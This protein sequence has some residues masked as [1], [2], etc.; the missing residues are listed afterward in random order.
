MEFVVTELKTKLSEDFKNLVAKKL[1]RFDRFFGEGTVANVKVT[2]EKNLECMEIT[3]HHEGRVYR[4]ES[5]SDS[6]YKSLDIAL[7]LLARKIEKNKTKLEKS[8]R[9]AIPELTEEDT[10]SSSY[11]DSDKEEYKITKRK[12][13]PVKP[14]SKE[15]AILQMNLVG[16]Q[17]FIFRDQAT[18]EMNLIYRRKNN[19]YG[20]I[21]P[22]N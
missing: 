2:V 10:E 6:L 9:N 8:F 11:G 13:F 21:E 18:N 20:L 14:M 19:T 22:E 1:S 17:F 16:H 12:S 5:I 7:D 15:E 4:T 3:I